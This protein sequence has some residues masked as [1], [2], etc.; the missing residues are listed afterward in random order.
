MDRWAQALGPCSRFSWLSKPKVVAVADRE[1]QNQHI[2]HV[3]RHWAFEPGTINA[4]VVQAS[5][6][7]EVVQMRIEMGVLQM[8]VEGRPDGERPEDA[9]T[10]LDALIQHALADETFTMTMEQCFEADREFLQFYHRRI[11]WPRQSASGVLTRVVGPTTRGNRVPPSGSISHSRT[12]L[13][14][15]PD[16]S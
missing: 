13:Y 1:E 10:Y 12:S 14:A 2:D 9:Q 6:G 8:E 4:R 15:R 7:R 16:S 11:C 3:I 5:G